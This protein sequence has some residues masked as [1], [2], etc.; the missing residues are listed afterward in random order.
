M[1]ART[2][3]QLKVA[4][5]KAQVEADRLKAEYEKTQAHA[6]VLRQRYEKLYGKR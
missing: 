2:K 5:T 3:A 4:L 6:E 1:K